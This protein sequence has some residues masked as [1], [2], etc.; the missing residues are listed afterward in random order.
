MNALTCFMLLTYEPKKS[1]YSSAGPAFAI[2][3]ILMEMEKCGY[4]FIDSD[5][6]IYVCSTSK[7]VFEYQRICME[8]IEKNGLVS[9]K[10]IL[11][12]FLRG[13]TY[14]EMENVISALMSQLALSYPGLCTNGKYKVTSEIRREAQG[15]LVTLLSYDTPN[16]DGIIAAALLYGTRSLSQ[17]LD[18]ESYK[19][20]TA[21][22][23]AGIKSIKRPITK[24]ILNNIDYIRGHVM[25]IVAN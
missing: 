16:K 22:I 6:K 4:I 5:G 24:F 13:F 15:S 10:N 8:I 14:H 25:G 18:K 3:G 21:V 12:F 1:Y 23:K 9:V 20:V 17:N 2:I 19:S 11:D 7:H